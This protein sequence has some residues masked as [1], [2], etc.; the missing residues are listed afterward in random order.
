MIHF[1][2]GPVSSCVVTLSLKNEQGKLHNNVKQLPLQISIK[3]LGC[4][5]LMSL[6]FSG[7]GT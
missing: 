2:L 1:W 7:V 6:L 3:W 4:T 5:S